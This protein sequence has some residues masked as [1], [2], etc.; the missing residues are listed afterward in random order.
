M[1]I[2]LISKA[3]EELISVVL[4]SQRVVSGNHFFKAY[5]SSPINYDK[6]PNRG[7]KRNDEVFI[8][9]LFLL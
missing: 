9:P 7:L 6:N 5:S 4:K 2:V 8:I 3:K 1:T